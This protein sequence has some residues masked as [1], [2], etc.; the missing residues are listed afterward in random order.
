MSFNICMFIVFAQ[1]LFWYLFFTHLFSSSSKHRKEKYYK[2]NLKARIFLLL[3]IFVFIY[4]ISLNIK[5]SIDNEEAQ[6]SID[7]NYTIEDYL[8]TLDVNRDNSVNVTEDITINVRSN[9]EMHGIL[10]FIPIWLK[11]TSKDGKTISKKAKVSNLSVVG[12][13]YKIDTVNGKKRIKVGSPDYYLEQGPEHYTIKYT[14]N[15]GK[16]IY[17]G[18]DEFIF[19]AFGDY[20]NAY[21]KNARVKIYL[22]EKINEE[23]LSIFL[24]KYRKDDA[25]RHFNY[26][27]N[28]RE[29]YI[30]AV[31]DYLLGNALTVD[32]ILPDGYFTGERNTYGFISLLFCLSIISITIIILI[33]WFKH[34]K[35]LRKYAETVEFNSPDGLDAASIGYIYKGDAGKKLTIATIIGLA[36]KGIIKIDDNTKDKNSKIKG[37]K[38]TN[39]SNFNMDNEINRKLDV[40]ILSVPTDKDLKVIFDKYF[41][42]SDKEVVISQNCDEFITD[43]TSLINAKIIHIKSDTK[44]EISESKK[45]KIIAEKLNISQNEKIVYDALFDRSNI[46]DLYND[47]NFYKTYNKVSEN[48]IKTYDEL[49]KDTESYRQRSYASI[50]TFIS[51]LLFYFA[52]FIIKDLNMKYQFIYYISVV[53]IMVSFILSLLM[54]RKSDMAEKLLAKIKGFKHYIET[55]EK[56]QLVHMVESNPNYFYDILPYAYVLGITNK[57][58]KKFEDI[59]VPKADYG[60]FDF[61]NFSSFNDISSSITYPASSSSGSSSGCSSCGGG[62][63]SCGGGCSSCGGGGSW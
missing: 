8:V 48:V 46:N 16:D 12:D 24:D 58:I 20:W 36:S 35:E 10:R 54:K 55:A 34:G 43:V 21:I 29:V 15:L 51:S 27:V 3:T 19:H 13:Q 9:G 61:T 1:V 45:S 62:C 40:E 14:Y 4:A 60:T 41:N 22:P 63:S 44:E 18:Y 6:Y 52:F 17:K 33:K 49:L 2:Y 39:I 28:G 37:I 30:Y 57:W 11:Y 50:L 25:S 31:D 5:K 7:Y 38:I 32:I 53:S 56:E 26:E 59:P 47:L 42:E 23:D